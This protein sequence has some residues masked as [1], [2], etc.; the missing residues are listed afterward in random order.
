MDLRLKMRPQPW[1]PHRTPFPHEG[2]TLIFSLAQT[3][4]QSDHL[5][6]RLQHLI[7]EEALDPLVWREGEAKSTKHKV[8][9]LV[10]TLVLTHNSSKFASRYAVTSTW[11]VQS[12]SLAEAVLPNLRF[13][14]LET[15]A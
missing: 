6:E 1:N 7:G 12:S 13:A 3:V 15:T 10:R 8:W 11:F 2:Q 9:Q 14:L 5:H 4:S